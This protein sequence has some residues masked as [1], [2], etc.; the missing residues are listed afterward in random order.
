MFCLRR[1]RPLVMMSSVRG[2]SCGKPSACNNILEHCYGKTS[3][4]VFF[5]EG[6][7][8]T[9]FLA[10]FNFL[11]KTALCAFCW[12]ALCQLFYFC[13]ALMP[14]NSACVVFVRNISGNHCL[15]FIISSSL[16]PLDAS[17][18]GFSSQLTYLQSEVDDM[19]Q[20]MVRRFDSKVWNC[21]VLLLRHLNIV[22]ESVQ[23]FT[24]SILISTSWLMIWYSLTE[25]T[26]ADNSNL[27]I[28]ISC[29]GASRAFSITK[30]QWILSKTSTK[31]R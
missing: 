15:F 19:R 31:H 22:V 20:I 14:I 2:W 28:V 30:L 13:F 24:R 25:I 27:G 4:V 26:A 1:P 11:R 6:L 9:C 18:A 23:Y 17:S 10:L 7:N 29:M 5:N 12:L 8:I 3:I 16:K 21:L